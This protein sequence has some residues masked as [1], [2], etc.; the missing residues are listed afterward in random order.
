MPWTES[1][2]NAKVK[3][4]NPGTGFGGPEF[5]G[6]SN[7]GQR[8]IIRRMTRK[9]GGLFIVGPQSQC[10]FG[11]APKEYRE[12]AVGGGGTKRSI[13]KGPSQIWRFRSRSA[14]IAKFTELCNKV[15]EFNERERSEERKYSAAL[16][17]SDPRVAINAALSRSL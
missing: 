3:R 12:F 5:Y 1:E 13:G 16:K 7:S 4:L 14:A 2:V 15:L 9:N 17:S 6:C 10:D 8:P 11:F